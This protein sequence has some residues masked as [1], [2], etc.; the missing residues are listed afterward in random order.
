MKGYIHQ[1]NLQQNYLTMEQLE[2]LIDIQANF[3]K[4]C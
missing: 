2:E 4:K 1:S 3:E